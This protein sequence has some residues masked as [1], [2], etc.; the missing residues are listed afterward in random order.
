MIST[1]RK[2]ERKTT[3]NINFQNLTLQKRPKKKKKNPQKFFKKAPKK[4]QS[5]FFFFPFFFPPPI[6]LL[7]GSLRRPDQ[8]HT[9]F[10]TQI[11]EM[12][13]GTISTCPHE[14]S[15]GELLI[16]GKMNPHTHKLTLLSSSSAPLTP[17]STG[18][19]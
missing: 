1:F 2:W 4:H 12:L 8:F 3:D 5:F 16:H 9:T 11:Y 13:Q 14:L 18:K 19:K 6:H 7:L 10:P 15:Q 17:C